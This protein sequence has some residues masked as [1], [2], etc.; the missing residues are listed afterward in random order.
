MLSNTK[1]NGKREKSIRLDETHWNLVSGL[2]PFYGSTEA[3]VVR[4]IVL[5]WL[6]QNIGSE[7]IQKLEELGAIN[8][9]D[10]KV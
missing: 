1:S 9:H 8:L 10:R 2:I 5:L 6:D 4:N 7:A 3:E